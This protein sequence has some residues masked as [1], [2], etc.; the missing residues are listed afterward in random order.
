MNNITKGSFFVF[1]ILML[2]GHS[3]RESSFGF[4][5][6]YE[7]ADSIAK[8]YLSDSYIQ[9]NIKEHIVKSTK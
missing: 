9:Y 2:H 1:E 7:L 6:T 4:Y 5:S 8:T 3:M